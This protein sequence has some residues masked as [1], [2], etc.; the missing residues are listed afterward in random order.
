MW[1]CGRAPQPVSDEEFEV[2]EIIRGELPAKSIKVPYRSSG[3]CFMHPKGMKGGTVYTL[4]FTPSAATKQLLR[5]RE[6][7]AADYTLRASDKL[8]VIEIELQ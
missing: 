7:N 2:I 6:N 5:E 8:E 3:D 1:L 4:R